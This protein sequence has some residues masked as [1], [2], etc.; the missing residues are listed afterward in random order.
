MPLYV[1]GF[2]FQQ[3]LCT[4]K[5]EILV[6]VTFDVSEKLRLSFTIYTYTETT[7]L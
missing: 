3:L 4:L 6:F 2:W 7:T 5:A 1:S